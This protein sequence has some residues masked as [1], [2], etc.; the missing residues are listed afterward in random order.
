[1]G[2]WF[3]ARGAGFTGRGGGVYKSCVLCCVSSTGVGLQPAGRGLQVEAAGFTGHA[4]YVVFQ[5]R[6]LVYSPW[7]LGRGLQVE[8]AGFTGHAFYVAFQARGWV[9]SPRGG[10]YRSRRRG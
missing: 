3:T 5:A 2:G 4:F 10:V 6:G 9:Y 1:M 7:A 8:A